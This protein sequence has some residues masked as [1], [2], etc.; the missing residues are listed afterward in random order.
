MEYSVRLKREKN[1]EFLLND[2]LSKGVLRLVYIFL[3]TRLNLIKSIDLSFKS[4]L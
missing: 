3:Y 4:F 2:K 1:K